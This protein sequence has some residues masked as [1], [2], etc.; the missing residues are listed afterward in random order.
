MLVSQANCHPFQHESYLWMHNGFLGN[1]EKCRR[2]LLASLSDSA[3]EIIKRNADSE[4]G[5]ALCLDELGDQ[6][7]TGST[8]IFDALIRTIA[9]IINIRNESACDSKTYMNFAVTNG[10]CSLFTRFSDNSENPPPTLYYLQLEEGADK[11]S[12]KVLIVAS[13]PL[14]EDDAWQEV[15]AG[16]VLVVEKGKTM[17][18][19]NIT[20]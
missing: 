19:R 9:R 1:F 12:E 5:F 8:Q 20:M 2:P 14:T 7:S 4:H 3:F 17:G 16:Q 6:S 15:I 13:E 18:I 10:H 11:T